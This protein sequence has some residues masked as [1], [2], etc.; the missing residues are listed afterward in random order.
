MS[1]RTPPGIQQR[2]P[3]WRRLWVL[4]LALAACDARSPAASDP[5]DQATM[6]FTSQPA[7]ITTARQAG[8]FAAGNA[9]S[10]TSTLRPL[11]P[12]PVKDVRLDTTPKIIE[13]SPGVKF[14][15]WTFGNQVPKP[16][17]RAHVGDKI[18]FTMTNRSDEPVPRVRVT[19]TPMM[20]SMVLE[21]IASGMYGAG[22]VEP[23]RRLPPR[24]PVST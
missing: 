11:D 7:R 16:T 24:W 23:P 22:I 15:G 14:S 10:T 13:I 3:A 1:G 21:H 2:R 8:A 18:R 12:A 9:L 20:H 5:H 4:A 6:D 17:I 19:A